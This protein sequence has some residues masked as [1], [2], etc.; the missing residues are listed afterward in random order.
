MLLSSMLYEVSLNIG[1]TAVLFEG[2]AVTEHALPGAVVR[3]GA[4]AIGYSSAQSSPS[5]ITSSRG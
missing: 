1:A 4:A 2:H 5:A 3:K